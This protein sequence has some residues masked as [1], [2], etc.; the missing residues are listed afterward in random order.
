[1]NVERILSLLPEGLLA[2]LTI[3]TEVNRYSKKLQGEVL[4]KLLIHC[5]LSHKENSLR[6]MESAYESIGFS[7]LNAGRKKQQVRYN[8]ISERLSTINPAYFEKIYQTCIDVYS[9]ELRGK[10]RGI[11][12]FDSTIVTLSSKLLHLG[13]LL[14]GGDASH[15]RQLKFTIGL[16]ELPQSVHLYTRLRN[17]TFEKQNTLK[18][19]PLL[20]FRSGLK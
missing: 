3:A 19:N 4:F 16:G 14:K 7:V 20:G 11:V 8:S 5:L 2:E 9:K 1:M 18:P 6:S 17:I 12:R 13:Y 15:V 10:S